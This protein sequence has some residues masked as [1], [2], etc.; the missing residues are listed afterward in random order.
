MAIPIVIIQKSNTT[1]IGTVM[2][3]LDPDIRLYPA[4]KLWPVP[5]ETGEALL[6]HRE[7]NDVV[8]L[9]RVAPYQK[10]T[11]NDEISFKRIIFTCR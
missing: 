8:Y 6:V 2:I 4:I 1:H 11:F 10:Y 7:G 5:S 3:I 9:K